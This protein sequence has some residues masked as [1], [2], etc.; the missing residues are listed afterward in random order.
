[1]PLT[2]AHYE[3]KRMNFLNGKDSAFILIC[4]SLNSIELSSLHCE[5]H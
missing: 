3:H 5:Q 4:V 2:I 1:M